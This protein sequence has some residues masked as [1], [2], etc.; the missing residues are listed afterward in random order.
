MRVFLLLLIMLL[1]PAPAAAASLAQKLDP[2]LMRLHRQND[3]SG[4]VAISRNGRVGYAR[5]FGLADIEKAVPF[6]PATHS[7]GA[8]LTKPVTAAAILLLAEEGL[9]GLDAPVQKY[10]REYPHS[11]STVRDLLSHSGGLPDYGHFQAMLDSGKPVSTVDLLNAL[12]AQKQQPQF[13]SGTAFG[14]CNLC[15]DALALAVERLTGQSFEAF[16]RSRLLGPAGAGTAFVR[17]ARF[18]DWKG[19]RTRGY[20][21]GASGWELNDAFDNEGFYGGDNI[22]FSAL[23]LANW[24]GAWAMGSEALRR[25]RAIATTPAMI[26]SGQSNLSLGNWYCIKTRDRCYYRGHHQ[27]FHSLA[28]WDS[29]RRISVAFVSNNTLAPHLHTELTR[30]LIAAAE[31]GRFSFPA[32]TAA[33]AVT[34]A[35]LKGEYS[36][37]SIGR[38]SIEADAAGATIQPP[39][40]VRYRLFPVAPGWFYAPGLDAYLLKPA[41]GGGGLRW[42]SVF[43]RSAGKRV[44]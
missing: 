3:F 25:I 14:Y 12:G 34:P 18:A 43:T 38:V 13:P 5:G 37:G 15:L 1:P 26:G 22:Y 8:S 33:A 32:A 29:K 28:Y 23:E 44:E 20:R 21:R 31:G 35:Q 11:Q 17:P 2:A 27:G 41:S 19:V 24:A 30:S 39:G 40:G 6:T 4:A 42:H 16:A 36:F 7:D 9:I 10:L